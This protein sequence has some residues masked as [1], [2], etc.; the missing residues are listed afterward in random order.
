MTINNLYLDQGKKLKQNLEDCISSFRGT[1]FSFFTGKDHG[2]LLV[3]LN[4]IKFQRGDV[5]KTH[6]DISKL[7]RI[8][9][10]KAKIDIKEGIKKF[11]A[12][13]NSYHKI[14]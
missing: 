1:Y 6:A 9:N 13:H 5:L 4:N 2:V 3:P 7:K 11:I 12:W 14:K 8:T 10:Y